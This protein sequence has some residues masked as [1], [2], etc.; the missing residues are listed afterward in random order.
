LAFRCSRGRRPRTGRPV[1]PCSH[2][3]L[4]ACPLPDRPDAFV[5]EPRFD[6][7]MIHP[8]SW[9]DDDDDDDLLERRTI[10]VN[11]RYQ[12]D[13]RRPRTRG[14]RFTI[15]TFHNPVGQMGSTL[16]NLQTGIRAHVSPSQ[17]FKL[18]LVYP[19]QSLPR[20]L[21]RGRRARPEQSLPRF[22]HRGRTDS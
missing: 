11:H 5:V 21:H 8:K 9:G 2:A 19:E 14:P 13:W 20:F 22:L 3:A 6:D 12:A 17:H 18:P 1:C 4:S 10:A 7:L 15:S 16:Y